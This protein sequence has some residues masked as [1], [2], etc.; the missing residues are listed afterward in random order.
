MCPALGVQIVSPVGSDFALSAPAQQ[1]SRL[2]LKRTIIYLNGGLLV[3]TILLIL[4]E[5]QRNPLKLVTRAF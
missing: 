3:A 5:H 1:D 2:C 4:Y